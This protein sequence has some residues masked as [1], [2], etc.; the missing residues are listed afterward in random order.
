MNATLGIVS[1][2]CHQDGDAKQVV[3]SRCVVPEKDTD[4]N[5]N[6]EK[7]LPS[8]ACVSPDKK[9]QREKRAQIL[10]G[11]EEIGRKQKQMQENEHV[12]CP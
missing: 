11:W 3:G 10:K 8:K 7:H 5:Q 4:K 9:K 6:L 2:G 12:P 1:L